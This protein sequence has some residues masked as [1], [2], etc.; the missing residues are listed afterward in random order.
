MTRLPDT[1]PIASVSADGKA[2]TLRIA[3]WSETFPVAHLDRRI[4]FYQSLAGRVHPRFGGNPGAG[5]YGTIIRALERARLVAS[6]YG[7]LT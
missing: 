2:V 6:A 4:A 3:I 5:H 7:D 1:K